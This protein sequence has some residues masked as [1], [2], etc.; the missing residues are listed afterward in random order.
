MKE[1]LVCETVFSGD[2]WECPSCHSA[3]RFIDGY[4]SFSPDVQSGNDFFDRGYFG[5]LADVEGG[6]W[7]FRSRN[8]LITG[9]LGRYFPSFS[10]L[11]EIGCGTGFVLSGIRDAFPRASLSGSELFSEG[12]LYARERLPGVSLFQMDARRIPFREEFDVVGAFD[13]I[14]HI[15][16]DLAVLKEIFKS[17]RK[18]GG[19]MLTVP[20]HR[21]LWSPVDEASFHKRRYTRRE[22]V[23]KVESAGF[24]IARMTSFFTLTFPLQ[25]ISRFRRRHQSPGGGDFDLFEEFRIPPWL[26]ILL[27]KICSAERSVLLREFS[28]PVG[29]SLLC[30]G[31]KE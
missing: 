16:E 24:R 7:W 20:Q 13:V 12:L 3:P 10:N 11:L 9:A 27:E 18:G 28:L 21:W 19:I 25:V 29:G 14:E 31:I 4:P 2:G 30:I 5:Q 15:G 23:G 22:L 26:N 8:R 1:C 6:N 17:V